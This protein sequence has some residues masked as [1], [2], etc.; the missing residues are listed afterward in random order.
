MGCDAM[1]YEMRGSPEKARFLTSIAQFN[2]HARF[3]EDPDPFCMTQRRAEYQSR[4]PFFVRRVEVDPFSGERVW[5][6]YCCWWSER[7]GRRGRESEEPFERI[8]RAGG[9]GEEVDGGEEGGFLGGGERGV[10][11]ERGSGSWSWSGGEDV[12]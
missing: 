1:R 6:W 9:G 5:I 2:V 8:G 3:D 10:G 11:S 4:V 7:E 12:E